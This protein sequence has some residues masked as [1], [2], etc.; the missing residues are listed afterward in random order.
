MGLIKKIRGFFKNRAMDIAAED[1][2]GLLG[3]LG[4]NVIEVNALY[5]EEKLEAL[6]QNPILD[7]VRALYPVYRG[8]EVVYVA[9]SEPI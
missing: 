6:L 8:Y 7:R 2:S 3:S 5:E 9:V 1:L 4:Y